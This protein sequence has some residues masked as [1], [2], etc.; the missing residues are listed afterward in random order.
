MRALGW[1]EDPPDDR[2]VDALRAG[3]L[4]PT[5]TPPSASNADLVEV[6]DQAAEG[7]CVSFSSGQAVRAAQLLELVEKKLANWV[8]A[9]GQAETFDRAK[10]L[11]E[12]RASVEFWAWDFPYYLA[13]GYDHTTVQDVGTNLRT[14]FKVIN[15]YG[16][17]PLSSMPYLGNTDRKKGPVVFDRMPPANAFRLAYDQRASAEN[18]A[19]NVV[20]YARITETGYARMDAIKLASSQR[21]LVVFGT[22]VSR[23]YCSGMSANGGKPFDPPAASTVAGGH[24]MC[25]GGYDPVSPLVAG[26]W[27]TDYNPEGLGD[28]PPGWSRLSW[29]YLCWDKTTDLWIVRRSPL[30]LQAKAA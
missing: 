12:A 28:V 2:D 20:D 11:S 26:S 15:K 22:L 27:S 21:H 9:G 1:R 25:V 7:A 29:D 4:S 8:A 17:P 30:F 6:Q 23:A 16:F 3:F 13:R 24:A 19:A 14:V 10:A 18:V 5:V